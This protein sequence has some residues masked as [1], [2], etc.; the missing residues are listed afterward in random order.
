MYSRDSMSQWPPH[1]TGFL[2]QFLA[3]LFDERKISRTTLLMN[4]K[5]TA[6]ALR[7]AAQCSIPVGLHFNLTE[8]KPI[9]GELTS[10]LINGKTK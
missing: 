3:E 7:L 4:G 6:H 8:G 5:F 1:V 9:S 2:L 10:K